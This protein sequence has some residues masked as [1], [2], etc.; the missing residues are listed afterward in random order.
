MFGGPHC[1]GPA[2]VC[3]SLYDRKQGL[4]E[5]SELPRGGMLLAV[6]DGKAAV[7][8]T[9][10]IPSGVDVA[11]QLYPSLVRGGRS[12]ASRSNDTERTWRAA[13][14]L[15]DKNTLAFVIGQSLSMYEFAERLIAAGAREAGYTDGG[16]SG[17]LW[18]PSA[19]FGAGN[20]RA[21]PSFLVA[22]PKKFPWVPILT[23]IGAALAALAAWWFAGRTTNRRKRR[24]L[25]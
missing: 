25:R 5:L 23:G 16:N 24:R 19:T 2:N 9:G 6:K 8:S 12:V 21:V 7:A 18:T 11:V 15:L 13:L 14:V 1:S 22:Y 17:T 20:A 3:F 4:H 10:A